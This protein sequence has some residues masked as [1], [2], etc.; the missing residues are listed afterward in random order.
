MSVLV[1]FH[2]IWLSQ[3]CA[4]RGVF[5][6]VLPL[7]GWWWNLFV[8]DCQWEWNMD[9]WLWTGGGDKK[10]LSV[11][12][13]HPT[14]SW[15]MKFQDYSSRDSH[16][17]S[18]YGCK[19]GDF[20]RHIMWQTINSYL[21]IKLLKPCRIISGEFDPTKMLQKSTF[22]MMMHDHKQDWKYRKQSQR[23]NGLF[24]LTHHTAQI[25]HPLH[26]CGALKNAISEKSLKVMTKFKKCKSGCKYKIK[27]GI[28]WR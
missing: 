3:N 11:E 5:R 17:P 7:K 4:E 19:S 6:F 25:L 26:H 8:K 23:S 12:W 15:K 16:D 1:R 13:H 21:Y 9:P 2:A 27:T 20:G 14:S 10:K 18:I 22:N 24:F 28:K